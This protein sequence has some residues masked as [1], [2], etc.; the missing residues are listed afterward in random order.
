MYR[1]IKVRPNKW[2][3][4]FSI[5]EWRKCRAI[6]NIDNWI[7]DRYFMRPWK[8]L[9]YLDDIEGYI[10]KILKEEMRNEK[11]SPKG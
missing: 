11:H 4:W 9:H 6:E 8:Y 7:I 10:K 2:Y 1:Y 3:K 5:T